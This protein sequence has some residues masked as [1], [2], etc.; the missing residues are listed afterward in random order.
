MEIE[1]RVGSNNKVIQIAPEPSKDQIENNQV[2]EK[3]K[4]LILSEETQHSLPLGK[5]ISF[6]E[7]NGNSQNSNDCQS[8]IEPE[9]T[10]TDLRKSASRIFGEGMLQ[11]I[12]SEEGQDNRTNTVDFDK[13]IGE[14]YEDENA[15]TRKLREP[16]GSPAKF[17]SSEETTIIFLN[18]QE[19]EAINDNYSKNKSVQKVEGEFEVIEGGNDEMNIDREQIIKREPSGTSTTVIEINIDQGKETTKL[20]QEE[21]KNEER[22]INI[23]EKVEGKTSLEPRTISEL[24]RCSH[25]STQQNSNVKT[26]TATPNDEFS[27]ADN[28]SA[29]HKSFRHL[30]SNGQESGFPL[31]HPERGIPHLPPLV[32]PMSGVPHAAIQGPGHSNGYHFPRSLPSVPN[33]GTPMPGGKR[34]IYLHL[35]QDMSSLIQPEKGGFLSFRRRKGI[36]SRMH[37]SISEFDPNKDRDHWEDRGSLTVSWYEGTSSVE[38]QEHVRNSVIRKLG[39]KGTTKLLDF[40]VLDESTNPP[41]GK[42]TYFILLSL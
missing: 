26:A 21:K 40:R 1:E 18:E 37:S 4:A 8:Q 10:L 39:I 34:K 42:I 12:M 36:K 11:N 20:Y 5:S 22:P 28:Y 33:Q 2:K 38:L 17:S 24:S 23:V 6:E 16:P 19:N 32:V 30:T 15:T 3:M 35:L 7:V 14:K 31:Q 13:M 29:D 41:E 27:P 9:G 25:V